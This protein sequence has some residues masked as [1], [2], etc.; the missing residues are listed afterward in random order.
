MGNK[1]YGFG[2]FK[3]V[4]TPSILTIIGVVMYLRFGWVLGNVG[5]LQSLI[6]LTASTAITFLTGLSIS[7]LATNMRVKGG[8]AYFMISRSFGIE[9]GAAI[10][11]PLFL[12]QAIAV[13][14]YTT[15]FVEA[16]C[17]SIPFAEGWDVRHVSLVVLVAVLALTVFSADLALKAQYFIMAAI[18]LSLV[19]FFLGGA[20]D[21]AT[22]KNVIPVS[23]LNNNDAALAIVE[24]RSLGF[25]TVLAVFFPAVTGILSGV[26]MSGDLTN[27]SRSIP[28]GT[29][30]AILVGYAVYASVVIFLDGFAGDSIQMRGALLEDQMFLAKCSRWTIPVIAGIWAACLSS[31]LGS[32]LAAPRVLQALSHDG[33][34]PRFLGRGFGSNDD[35]RF[36]AALT[37]IIAAVVVYCGNI[38]AIA[39]LLTMFNLTVYCLLN[40]SA[41]LEEL[42]GNPSWRPSFRVR[43]TL[44]FLGAAGCLIMM[45]MI[46]PGST[47]IAIGAIA[48]IFWI[49]QARAMKARWGDMRFGLL[50][51]LSR[52]AIRRLSMRSNDERNWRPILLVFA[53]APTKRW[54]L[55]EVA[56][57]ISHNRSLVTIASIIPEDAWSIDR[58]ESMRGTIRSV[59][60]ERGIEAQVRIQ[61]GETT[62]SGM[63]ELVRSYGWGPL[64]PNTVLMGPTRKEESGKPFGSLV[65]SLC[66]R[67][68]NIVIV[69]D[70][71][72]AALSQVETPVIDIWWRGGNSNAP[73]MLSLAYLLMRD[74]KWKR[75]RLRICHLAESPEKVDDAKRMLEVFVRDSRV[76]AECVV[77]PPNTVEKPLDTICRASSNS[78]L[79]FLGLRK[80]ADDESDEAYGDY[81]R[82]YE[83]RTEHLPLV[84]YALASEDVDFRAIFNNGEGGK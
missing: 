33:A 12:S 9:A 29:I 5:L 50:M 61:P 32:M 23:D 17:D 46:S 37:F 84:I 18:G 10:G 70:N 4:F 6:I 36:A 81:F 65:R 52:F 19:S 16:F 15:G 45:F 60:D 67:Q 1:G 11:I 79:V 3:G 42:M 63:K 8:G 54:H 69:S 43:S 38:N 66:K 59:L 73:F 41:G 7:A 80:P 25:W 83:T 75:A 82:Y 55:I 34:T 35:P 14:F 74:D 28:L 24:S 48:A 76:E 39:T 53:G 72:N 57:A 56:G 13:A 26:G 21:L 58:A 49:M 78:D 77:I 40:L 44:S 68:C 30:A 2:A 64:I 27:P 20:P 22:L 47:F 71:D 31:A 51:A 62:W